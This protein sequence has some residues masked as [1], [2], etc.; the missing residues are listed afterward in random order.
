MPTIKATGRLISRIMDRP[1]P[2]AIASALLAALLAQTSQASV[3]PAESWTFFDQSASQQMPAARYRSA[4]LFSS[5][6]FDAKTRQWRLL[7][8]S[9]YDLP[10]RGDITLRA[11]YDEDKTR[12]RPHRIETLDVEPQLLSS[13]PLEIRNAVPSTANA[14]IIQLTLPQTFI[15]HLQGADRVIVDA[16]SF[17]HTMAMKGSAKAIAQIY[18]ALGEGRSSAGKTITEI[19][20]KS[21]PTA[22][23]TLTPDTIPVAMPE[24][25]V[26]ATTPTPVAEPTSFPNFQC[27]ELEKDADLES[28][29]A[30]INDYVSKL[31]TIEGTK[32]YK[33]MKVW[34]TDHLG[35][36]LYNYSEPQYPIDSK[37][38]TCVQ[39]ISFVEERSCL[40]KEKIKYFDYI[41]DHYD[42][43]YA[44]MPLDFLGPELKEELDGTYDRVM[45]PYEKFKAELEERQRELS[46]LIVRAL[47]EE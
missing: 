8:V 11:V 2:S 19:V 38:Q 37:R 42:A 31:K 39:F 27:G 35:S 12:N 32:Y 23:A 13:L 15:I 26:A 10:L 29:F 1:V 3:L 34:L 20:N 22:A 14:R 40:Q 44:M 24:H 33:T 43:A 9:G 47:Q 30:C 18:V 45:A 16:G 25:E 46:I 17:Q 36:D 7:L 28:Y 6:A 21:G 4:D 41:S 5:L